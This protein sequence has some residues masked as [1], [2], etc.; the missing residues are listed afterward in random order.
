MGFY[1]GLVTSS[2]SSEPSLNLVEFALSSMT[3]LYGGLLGVFA[4]AVLTRN[5]GTESA[6]IRGLALG[7]VVGLALFL[8]PILLDRTVLAWTWWIPVSA[9][10]SAAATLA[11]NSIG[12]RTTATR[13]AEP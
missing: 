13:P 9:T 8:H 10:V 3:I 5:A 1:H 12:K 4:V 7:G 2:A 6:A 11:G